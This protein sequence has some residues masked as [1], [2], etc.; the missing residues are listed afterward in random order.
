VL[1]ECHFLAALCG[2]MD[3]YAETRGKHGIIAQA[4]PRT[5]GAGC[6]CG[7]GCVDWWLLCDVWGMCLSVVVV[8]ML[9]VC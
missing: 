6:V 7:A 5:P 4:A 2:G 1:G 8:V 3:D 9:C